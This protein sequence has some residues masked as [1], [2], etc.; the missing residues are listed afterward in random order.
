MIVEDDPVQ[1]PLVCDECGTPA[2]C[3]RG[4]MEHEIEGDAIRHVCQDCLDG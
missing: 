1:T 3:A 4:H 2:C